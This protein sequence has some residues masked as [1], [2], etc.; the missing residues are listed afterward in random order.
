MKLASLVYK[1][2]EDFPSSEKFNLV[3]QVQRSAVSIPSNIAEGAGRNSEKEF[4]YFLS[5]AHGSLYELE[6]QLLIAKDL[7]YLNQ[8]TTET[9]IN[10]IHEIQKMSYSF[11]RKLKANG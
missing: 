10:K 9:L 11:Q 3:S 6:T 1:T 5:I 7:K 8:E 4:L 2:C